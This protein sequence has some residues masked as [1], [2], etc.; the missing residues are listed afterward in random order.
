M[1]K[2]KRDWLL[3]DLVS[4]EFMDDEY[5]KYIRNLFSDYDDLEKDTARLDWLLEHGPDMG[6]WQFYDATREA[7]DAVMGE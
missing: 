1:D 5:I 4:C 6:G 7:I 2:V 3:Q